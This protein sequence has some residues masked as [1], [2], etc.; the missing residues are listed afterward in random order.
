[1]A[2][3]LLPEASAAVVMPEPGF[4]SVFA[5]EAFRKRI[6]TIAEGGRGS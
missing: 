1:M 4:R 3:P 6:A 2:S 5:A